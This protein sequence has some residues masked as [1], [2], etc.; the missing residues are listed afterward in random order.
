MTDIDFDELD[1]AVNSLMG[2][3]AV[4]QSGQDQSTTET[5]VAS[6]PVS[7][8]DSSPLKPAVVAPDTAASV[9]PV[10][11]VASSSRPASIATK[12]RGQFMDVMHPSAKMAT[13]SRTPSAASQISRHGVSLTPSSGTVKPEPAVVA[14]ASQATPAIAPLATPEWPDPLDLLSEKEPASVTTEAPEAPTESPEP[15]IEPLSSPFLPDAKVEKR[16]LG[17]APALDATAAPAPVV[18]D[19]KPADA[20]EPAPL[21]VELSGGVLAVESSEVAVAEKPVESEESPSAADSVTTPEPSA[22]VETPT[23]APAPE[24]PIQLSGPAS[25]PPQYKTEQVSEPAEHTALYDAV[26]EAHSTTAPSKKKNGWL[27]PLA[28]VGFIVLGCAGGV[29]VYYMML[30]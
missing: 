9:P 7:S 27:V 14:P 2:D 8:V 22:P 29:A 21:P 1:K 20:E 4:P 28:I 26:S 23:E 3:R 19:E 12:R 6:E 17:S 11:V 5:P 15:G 13:G 30:K 10:P 25:I 24:T 18:P 16:P